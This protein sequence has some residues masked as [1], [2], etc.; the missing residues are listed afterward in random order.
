VLTELA[1]LRWLL[2]I[3]RN[4]SFVYRGRA[5]DIREIGAQLN[6]Q[7]V[8]EG[9]AG[10]DKGRVR[11]TCRLIEA[12]T[13]LQIWSSRFERSVTDVFQLLGEITEAVVSEIGPAILDAERSR[14]A[15][16][17]PDSLTTWEAYQRGV[18]H[19]LKPSI[20]ANLSAR[21]FFQQAVSLRSDYSP[22]FD[23]LAWTHLVD[24]SV[25]SRISIDEGCDL[26]E[27]LARRALELDPDNSSARARLALTL[28]LRGDNDAAIDDIWKRSQVPIGRCVRH[29]GRRSCS[30][31][32]TVKGAPQSRNS[33]ALVR[34]I[35][36]GR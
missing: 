8:L 23:G 29:E 17:P 28:H 9:S 31:V 7:Y 18:A 10:H 2:V 13:A 11:V 6:V 25:F 21:Q 22:G 36:Q 32:D 20:A 30:P 14:I 34:A 4:S 12:K 1:R 3:A 33:C 15:Q 16:L 24:A 19:M 5:V 27:P 35:P 26:S